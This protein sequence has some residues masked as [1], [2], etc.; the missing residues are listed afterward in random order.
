[1]KS[2]CDGGLEATGSPAT[3]IEKQPEAVPPA[4]VE[5]K[6]HPLP[7]EMLDAGTWVENPPNSLAVALALLL[8]ALLAIGIVTLPELLEALR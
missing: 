7:V 1:M 6:S 5:S 4:S 8:V 2:Q 3:R